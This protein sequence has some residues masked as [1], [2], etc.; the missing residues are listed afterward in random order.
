VVIIRCGKMDCANKGK[1][2]CTTSRIKIDE[3]GKCISYLSFEKL[4]KQKPKENWKS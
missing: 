1:E 2:V 4:M 3:E